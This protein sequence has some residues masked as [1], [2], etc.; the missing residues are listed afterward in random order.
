MQADLG[1]GAAASWLCQLTRDLGALQ[2]PDS[3]LEFFRGLGQLLHSARSSGSLSEDAG[4]SRTA[5][6]QSPMGIF[7]RS[8]LVAFNSM[9]FEVRP[10]KQ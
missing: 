7:L 5:E 10:C 2:T 8:C 4:H 1:D 3:V 6:R 9:A